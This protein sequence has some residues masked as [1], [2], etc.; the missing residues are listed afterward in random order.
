MQIQLPSPPVIIKA[1]PSPKLNSRY[2]ED[3]YKK[4]SSVYAFFLPDPT[5]IFRVT[6]FCWVC[7][8]FQILFIA[9]GVSSATKCY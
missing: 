7:S 3:K 4:K 2:G 8:D 1:D 5:Q 9:F 6:K